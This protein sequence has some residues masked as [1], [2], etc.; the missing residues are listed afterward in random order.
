M[1]S[2]LNIGPKICG[3]KPG[4]GAGFLRAINT[5]SSSSFGEEAKPSGPF[6]K[7]LWHA[8]SLQSVM[9]YASKAKFIVSFIK[10]LLICH[11][12]TLLVGL[13]ESALVDE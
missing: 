6:C 12:T 3:F 13:P 11:L 2:V 4:R 7:I 1:V 10:F 5:C 8:K 9:N